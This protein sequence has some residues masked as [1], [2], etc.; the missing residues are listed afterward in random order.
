MILVTGL[1]FVMSLGALCIM[2]LVGNSIAMAQRREQNTEA[3][4]MADAGVDLAKSWLSQQSTPPDRSVLQPL[5]NFFGSTGTF[6][7]PFGTSPGSTLVVRIDAATSN[8]SVHPKHYLVESQALLANGVTVTVRAYLQQAS[9]GK[10]AYFTVNDGGGFWD[11]NNHFEGPFHSNDADG[12]HSMFLWNSSYQ[13]NPIFTYTGSD[14]FSVSG[15]VTW[16]KN[17][18]GNTVSPSTVSD[19][20]S[21]ALGGQATMKSGYKTDSNGNYLHDNMGNKIVN[22]SQIPLPTTSY[23]QQYAALGIFV[24]G[25]NPSTPS[26]GAPTSA[27]VTF[28]HGGGLY[29]H[30]DNQMALSVDSS[31]RQVITV[32]QGT[33]VQTVTVDLAANDT[34]V[35]TQVGTAAATTVTSASVP[36]GLVYSD[37]NITSLQGTIANNVVSGGT[38]I[39]NAWTI[40]TDI[41][42][43]K[44]VT[45]TGSIKYL[46]PRN[47]AV[48]ETSDTN[49]VKYAGLLGI[50]SN[51][52]GVASGAG[53]NLE[54]DGSIFAT[55]TFDALNP[56]APVGSTGTMLSIGGVITQNAGVF[57]YS[58][59]SGNLTSGYQEQYHY[60]TRLANRPPPF[61]PTTGSHYDVISWQCEP[62][63]LN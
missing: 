19:F 31:G 49:F 58:D 23:A 14:A 38:T 44:N 47:L 50:L 5:N 9:F 41:A 56:S 52:V 26:P 8:P 34:I 27:G 62:G 40:A 46:T 59:N 17:T 28:V 37:G 60:D 51:H 42:A 7:N 12:Q 18:V 16:W 43:G 15:D 35:T 30:G 1:L 55:Q 3:F 61:F 32:T 45:L 24:G 57:A 11:F 4:N 25:A 54:F 33:T 10:Y 29:I 22:S 13:T 2:T 39:P 53:P 63:L 20:R 36:N 6:Y 48:Q 21:V